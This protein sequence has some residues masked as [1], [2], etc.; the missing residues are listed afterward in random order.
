MWRGRLTAS[1][2]RQG[3]REGGT[4]GIRGE[5]PPLGDSERPPGGGHRGTVGLSGLGKGGNLKCGHCVFLTLLKRIVGDKLE[6]ATQSLLK[7]NLKLFP[8]ISFLIF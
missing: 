3:G 2:N 4:Y 8:Q 5:E 1:D 7:N 6:G